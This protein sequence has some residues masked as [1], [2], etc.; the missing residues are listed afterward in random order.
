[1]TDEHRQRAIDAL[2]ALEGIPMGNAAH[3]YLEMLA[4]LIGVDTSEAES[5]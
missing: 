1:M 4:N 3:Y 2:R 5:P